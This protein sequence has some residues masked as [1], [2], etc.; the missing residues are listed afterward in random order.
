MSTRPAAIWL[1]FVAW[2]VVLATI[3]GCGDSGAG[4]AGTG[5]ES[6]SGTTALTAKAA[7]APP[8]GAQ[9]RSRSACG[10]RLGGLLNGLDRLRRQLAVGLSFGEY[11]EEIGRVRGSYRKLDV[12]RLPVDCLIARGTPAERALNEYIEAANAWGECLSDA[13]CDSTV[14]EPKLQRRWQVA[15]HFLSVAH[16]EAVG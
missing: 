4:A 13:G 14:V 10:Q 5:A 8:G 9:S 6:H 12:E 2:G 15:S 7:A 1:S 3:S 11:R 16:G